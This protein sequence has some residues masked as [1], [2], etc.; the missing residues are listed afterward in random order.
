MS[1]LETIQKKRALYT[2]LRPFLQDAQIFE[3]LLLWETRY[4]STPTFSVRYFVADVVRDINPD[5][6]HKKLLVALLSSMLKPAAEL[7]PD[8]T[9]AMEAFRKRGPAAT[10]QNYAPMPELEAFQ[11]FVNKWLSLV[12]SPIGNDIITF[13]SRNLPNLDI[14]IDLSNK[15]TRWLN[16]PKQPF[17][18]ARVDVADLRKIINLFYISFCEYLGPTRADQLMAQAINALK[19]NGGAAYSQLY[20][21]LL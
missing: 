12:A 14:T 13:V 20:A 8:P 16:N 1:N 6:E 5:I 3:A 19:N 11:L 15:M 7:L 17:L 10:A 2:G 4:A 18:A 21:K 9:A